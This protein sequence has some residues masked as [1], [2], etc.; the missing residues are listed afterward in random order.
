MSSCSQTGWGQETY[1]YRRG[2]W[3]KVSQ[4]LALLSEIKE[5]EFTEL[6][7]VFRNQKHQQIHKLITIYIKKILAVRNTLRLWNSEM[8]PAVGG[9]MAPSS[10]HKVRRS[11]FTRSALLACTVLT[12]MCMWYFNYC[13]K[14]KSRLKHTMPNKI[15]LLQHTSVH[16]FGPY[17][18]DHSN[19][20]MW[21]VQQ[22]PVRME[23][24]KK[25]K[26]PAHI[27]VKKW[28]E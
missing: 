11:W 12:V 3:V 16:C 28:A 2:G 26:K 27:H 24:K 5:V 13:E 8:M 14:H 19:T 20:I 23:I 7:F 4:G 21:R 15:H 6:P 18:T 22:F 17:F 1:T 9:M 10:H 25:C